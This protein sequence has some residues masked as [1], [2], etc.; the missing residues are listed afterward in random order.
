M[1]K[2]PS[3]NTDICI[4]FVKVPNYIQAIG[5]PA[6]L[7]S[8]EDAEFNTEC[9]EDYNVTGLSGVDWLHP[10]TWCDRVTPYKDKYLRV[11]AWGGSSS[12]GSDTFILGGLRKSRS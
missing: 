7:E 5:K 1:G 2:S 3:N 8:W 6:W 10:I 12:I 4:K 11:V 9:N